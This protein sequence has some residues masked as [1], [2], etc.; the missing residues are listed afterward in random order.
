MFRCLT[1]SAAIVLFLTSTAYADPAGQYTV[2]GTNPG[3]SG[4]YR[5]TVTVEPTGETFKVT[6]VVGGERYVGTGIGDKNF[7]AV[8]YTSGKFSGL[9][10]YGADGQGWSGVWTYANGTRMGNEKWTPR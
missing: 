10:L 9:A 1:K 8:S 6:W 3:N 2:Q 5:G 4:G 7:L